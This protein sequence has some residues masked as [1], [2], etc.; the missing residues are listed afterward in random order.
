[1]TS[2]R[3]SSS[4]GAV[5]ALRRALLYG[6]A[7]TVL[8]AIVGSVIGGLVSGV[9]GLLSALIGAGMGFAFLGLTAASLLLADRVTGGDLLAPAYFGIV[10]G[11]WLVKF[12]A[13]F[14]LIV[15]L[16]DAVFV[17]PVVL[18]ITL[19]L[20]VLGGLITDIV[21]VSRSRI[22]YVSDARLPGP[23]DPDSV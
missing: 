18:F 8:I 16:R 1:M 3:P 15:A 17:D 12:I 23:H 4:S 11:S 6:A 20:A 5:S 14:V 9:P 7:I 10:L 13:F 21:A 22:P 2:V 19:V